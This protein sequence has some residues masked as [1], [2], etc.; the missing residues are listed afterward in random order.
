MSN[1][2]L[3][4]INYVNI[5]S[6]AVLALFDNESLYTIDTEGCYCIDLKNK[7]IRNLLHFYIKT[8]VQNE[9]QYGKNNIVINTCRPSDNWRKEMRGSA[10]KACK[11]QITDENFKINKIKLEDILERTWTILSKEL[12]KFIWITHKNIDIFDLI[13]IMQKLFNGHL[14]IAHST[15]ILLT[16]TNNDYIHY[17]NID[18]KFVTEIEMMF[19]NKKLIM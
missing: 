1:N 6:N 8:M 3:N 10:L 18:S 9:Y 7:D 5:C 12:N 14:N 13:I 4:V 19:R 16:D 2:N 11:Y 15:Y 17:D